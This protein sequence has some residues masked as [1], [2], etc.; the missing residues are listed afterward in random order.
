VDTEG[1][2]Y[3]DG[4]GTYPNLFN[5]HPPFQI[6][7]NFGAASG[8]AEMLIQSREDRIFI[9]PALPE[10]WKTGMANG[11][12]AKGGVTADMKWENGKLVSLCLHCA[13]DGAFTLYCGGQALAV[14]AK[15]GQDILFR[16]GLNRA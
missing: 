11:L 9:L 10:A 5:A 6:D 13:H 16:D 2:N 1:F 3:M 8:I 12:C 14:Q 7:G 4:G 15:E